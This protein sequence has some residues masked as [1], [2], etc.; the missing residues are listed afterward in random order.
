MIPFVRK[1]MR[2]ESTK[3]EL[4]AMTPAAESGDTGPV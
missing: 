2:K 1:Q 3:R 4:A